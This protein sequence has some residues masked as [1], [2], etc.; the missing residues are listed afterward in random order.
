MNVVSANTKTANIDNVKLDAAKSGLIK[1]KSM[2]A[3]TKVRIFAWQWIILGTVVI[4]AIALIRHVMFDY[5][6]P[7]SLL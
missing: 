5:V 1:K 6:G 4:A 2:Q 3:D 7:K